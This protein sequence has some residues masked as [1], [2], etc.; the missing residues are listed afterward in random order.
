MYSKVEKALSGRFGLAIDYLP[1]IITHLFLVGIIAFQWKLFVIISV[2][3]IEI[4]FI[5][6][7]L[8]FTALFA[9]QPIDDRNAEKWKREPNLVRTIP[10][11]PPVY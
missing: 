9:A 10:F 3:V 6:I 11:L 7:L 5:N 1:P 4:A 2:P 8:T